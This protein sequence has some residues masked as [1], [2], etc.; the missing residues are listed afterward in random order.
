MQFTSSQ[1]EAIA[2][3]DGHLQIVACAGS[4]KTEVVAQRVAQLLLPA[5]TPAGEAPLTPK[6]IIA[7][8]FTEKAAAELKER[9]HRRVHE[10]VGPIHGMA[11]MYVGT[12]HGFCLDLLRNEVAALSKFDVL[13]SVQQSL[14]VERYRA[15]SGFEATFDLQAK[16]LN[17]AKETE[18]FLRALD[19]LRQG[20]LVPE[21]L[22]GNS[23]VT[24]LR[25]YRQLLLDHS[26]F[27]YTAIMEHALQI[28]QNDSSVRERL[29]A[30]VR[31]VIVDEYQDTNPI[32]ERVVSVLASLGAQLCVVGDDDQT[33]YQWNGAD[34]RQILTFTER[35][36]NV[37]TVRLQENFRSSR[38]IVELARNFIAQ[39]KYRLAKEMQA[40]EQ[41]PANPGD[42]TALGFRSAADEV[43]YIVRSI[44]GLRGVSF[45]E[46]GQTRGLAYADMAILIRSNLQR[47]ATEITA[48][49]GAAGIPFLV[50]GMNN[51]FATP[52][53]QAVRAFFYFIARAE[54]IDQDQLKTIFASAGLGLSEPT[55]DAVVGLAERTRE[56]LPEIEETQWFAYR[57]QQRYQQLLETLAVKEELVPQGRGEVVFYN[58]AQFSALIADFEK[59]HYH[60]KPMDEYADFAVFLKHSAE[61]EYSEGL[62][63]NPYANPDAVRILTVHKAKGLQWPVVFVPGMGS[64]RF[65]S[66]W[67]P[68]RSVWS[69]V[70]EAGVRDAQRYHGSIED[71]RRLFYVAL[72][73]AQKYFLASF[74]ANPE[75]GHSQKPSEFFQWLE[76]AKL[77]KR[78]EKS[79]AT[80]PHTTSRAK[81]AVAN[82]KLTFSELKYFFEC[83]YRFKLRVLYGF[84]APVAEAAGYGKSLHAALAEVHQK[85][86]DGQKL[87]E[88]SVERLVAT[89]MH[90]P[91]AHPTLR[92][93]LE[94]SA[95]HVLRGYL[96]TNQKLLDQVAFVEKSIEVSLGGG[97]SV[98]GRMDLV[99]NREAVNAGQ[100]PEVA[101][102]DLKSTARAQSED[103]SE[104]QLHIYALGY[105]ELTG[106]RA[107]AVEVWE[108]E[109]AR[110]TSEPVDHSL[111]ENVKGK[112]RLVADALRENELAPN[113]SAATCGKCDF[114]AMCS[115]A[116]E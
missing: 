7:F 38:T 26:Y 112:I 3:R 47:N 79:F 29:R 20:E 95:T 73:R 35:Y 80:R 56:D 64:G 57:L 97:V 43:A 34:V 39:N 25:R 102:V 21:R 50:Q 94:Q 66:T 16:P 22:V 100:S 110:K 88:S 55:V 49:L 108:L 68:T 104:T 116:F 105:E 15:E 28:L 54:R 59:I 46:N 62:Q 83:P 60:S 18:L 114:R 36:P 81:A 101:I 6:S 75:Y 72:T 33:L 109:E 13:N 44:Q 107:H 9:I 30:R 8:T 87:D 10:V 89:H 76:S 4:G 5:N 63:N 32:Q 53:A 27:D 93:Q 74:S 90:V 24:A 70:P 12:I 40:T 99:Y 113:P 103:V 37:H 2:H 14:L 58:L 41:Q 52:E 111:I 77:V 17:P 84:H 23:A 67:R 65:P 86:M 45:T 11:E 69:I 48:A 1:Q 115:K 85:A 31:H 42:V 71:E 61:D 91:F 106:D 96:Q 82:V 92:A 51:L 19:L 78:V 98:A